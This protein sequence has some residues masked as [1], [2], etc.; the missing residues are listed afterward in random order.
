MFLS[1][2]I[3]FQLVEMD[4]QAR[5]LVFLQVNRQLSSLAASVSLSGSKF[6]KQLKR[7]NMISAN[8]KYFRRT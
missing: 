7:G 6:Y 3:C 1:R 5:A 8:S 4:E 2:L